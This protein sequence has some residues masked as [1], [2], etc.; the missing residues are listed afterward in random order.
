[1]MLRGWCARC[2]I[3]HTWTFQTRP[4]DKGVRFEVKGQC[5]RCQGPVQMSGKEE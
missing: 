5:P 3:P 2:Q 4:E 1:M